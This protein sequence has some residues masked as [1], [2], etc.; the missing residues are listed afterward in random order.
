[1]PLETRYCSLLYTKNSKHY[2]A[3]FTVKDGAISNLSIKGVQGADV[4]VLDDA[5][6]LAIRNKA[7]DIAAALEV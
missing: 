7:E 4:S 1:M 2:K 5:D 6:M 3:S